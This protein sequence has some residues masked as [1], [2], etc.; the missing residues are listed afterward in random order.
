MAELTTR[1]RH[2][3][4]LLD[5]LTDDEPQ[6]KQESRDKRVMSSTQVRRSVLRDLAWLL[7]SAQRFKPE[8]LADYPQVVSSVINY[9]I[10]DFCGL[11]HSSVQPGQVERQVQ[12]ALVRF[13]PR[14]LRRGLS[15]RAA[16]DTAQMSRNAVVFEIR[17]E[18]WAQPMPEALYVKTAMDL[19]T[20]SV[21]VQE[22]PYG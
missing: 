9:G 18:L 11:T 19:E 1:E 16:S 22:R 20:G 21:S 3:P 4:C 12:D 2:Q 17:G 15:V 8:E 14:V 6:Q 5:R 10:P 13:E 7:N